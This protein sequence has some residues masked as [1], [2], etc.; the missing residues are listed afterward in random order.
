MNFAIIIPVIETPLAY[1]YGNND[2]ND[3]YEI[4]QSK[5]VEKQ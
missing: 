3:E 2:N 4:T 1:Y 5:R